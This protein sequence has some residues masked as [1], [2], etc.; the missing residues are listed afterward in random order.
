MELE[1]I[2]TNTTEYVATISDDE[3]REA[4][5]EYVANRAGV[6]IGKH[7]EARVRF[8][9]REVSPEIEQKNGAAITARVNLVVNHDAAPR[10]PAQV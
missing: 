9:R 6:T 7:T 5:A 8:D 4:L 1:N 3:I 2:R 10:A